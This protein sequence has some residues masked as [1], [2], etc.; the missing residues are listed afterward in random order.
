MWKV[1]SLPGDDD[2]H[3]RRISGKKQVNVV[4]LLFF[5]FLGTSE[6]MIILVVA[7]M[8]FGPRKLPEM[9]R[10]LGRS[11][12]EFKRASEDFRQTW[13]TEVEREQVAIEAHSSRAVLPEETPRAA[14]A[15]LPTGET[16]DAATA[17]TTRA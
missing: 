4:P 16:F 2:A 14:L 5:E 1:T 15:E 9:G 8:V 13:E 12:A 10:S 7:L 6:L 3:R 11:I 17:S